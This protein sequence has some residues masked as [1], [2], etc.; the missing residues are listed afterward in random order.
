LQGGESSRLPIS[1]EFG[2][3]SFQGMIKSL[4]KL[5]DHWDGK[6][7]QPHQLPKTC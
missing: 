4:S 7:A 1:S 2:I 6:E 3:C 5:G